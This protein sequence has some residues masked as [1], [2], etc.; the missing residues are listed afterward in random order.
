MMT[1]NIIILA[2]IF[3]SSFYPKTKNLLFLL[4]RLSIWKH[5]RQPVRTNRC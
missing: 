3:F 1:L 4:L 5:F 2:F